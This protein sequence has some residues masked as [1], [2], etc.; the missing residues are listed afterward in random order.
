MPEEELG[1]VGEHG[2][3]LLVVDDEVAA[4]GWLYTPDDASG[5]PLQG[6]DDLAHGTLEHP[7]AEDDPAVPAPEISGQYVEP[8]QRDLANGG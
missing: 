4:R 7:V 1:H 6:P 2:L 8:A 5:P 3:E